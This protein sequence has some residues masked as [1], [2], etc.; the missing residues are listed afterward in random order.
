M[1]K[2]FIVA[3]NKT[4]SINRFYETEMDGE[5]FSNEKISFVLNSV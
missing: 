3:N 5:L 2:N 1:L 4:A